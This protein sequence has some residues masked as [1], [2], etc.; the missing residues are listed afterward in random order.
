MQGCAAPGSTLHLFVVERRGA[1]DDGR[2][3]SHERRYCPRCAELRR[4]E[5]PWRGWKPLYR[6]W[7]GLCAIFLLFAPMFAA[8]MIIAYPMAAT[9]VIGGAPLKRYANEVPRCRRC[10]LHLADPRRASWWQRLLRRLSRD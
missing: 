9:V 5:R 8:D 3:G 7:L 4:V 2:G 10:K 6:G 1:N